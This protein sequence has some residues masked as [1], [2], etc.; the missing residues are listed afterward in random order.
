MAYSI[1]WD[2]AGPSGATTPADTI[3]TELQNLKISIRERIESIICDWSD[4][5]VDPKVLCP[6]D[7]VSDVLGT[8]FTYISHNS[9][10]GTDIEVTSTA[11]PLYLRVGGTTDTNSD[12][13]VDFTK[14]NA[15]I[16]LL[17]EWTLFSGR[18]FKV[19]LGQYDSRAPLYVHSYNETGEVVRMH[20]VKEG[21]DGTVAGD[22]ISMSLIMVKNKPVAP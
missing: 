4:D 20:I 22:F 13:S 11:G 2:E 1:P 3:D 19:D 14:I 17:A 12:L 6:S 7:S 15:G 16:Y 10:T 5:S 9:D 18:G 8:A 21:G